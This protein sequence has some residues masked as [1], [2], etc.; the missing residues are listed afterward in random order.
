M[1]IFSPDVGLILRLVLAIFATYRIARAVTQ[2]GI[3]ARLRE[4]IG[5]AAGN[6]PRYSPR[7]YLAELL[8]CAFC[9]GWWVAAPIAGLAL[10][11]SLI[12][13][14]LLFWWGIAGAQA[15]MEGYHDPG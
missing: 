6:S 7:W 10:N 5:R 14:F 4:R 11:G 1:V 13:T 15:F 12:A 8:N 9:A 3:S 2:D